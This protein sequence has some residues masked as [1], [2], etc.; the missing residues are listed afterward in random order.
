[1]LDVQIFRD[2]AADD[3]G[4]NLRPDRPPLENY[5]GSHVWDAKTGIKWAHSS[6]Q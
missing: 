6:H 2:I 3:G 5:A 1:M 4:N